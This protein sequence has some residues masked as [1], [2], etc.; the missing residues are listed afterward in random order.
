MLDKLKRILLGGGIHDK[1]NDELLDN[2]TKEQLIELVNKQREDAKKQAEELRKYKIELLKRRDKREQ[3]KQSIDKYTEHNIS[4]WI[5]IFKAEDEK[6]LNPEIIAYDEDVSTFDLIKENKNKYF[7]FRP[8]QQRFIEDWSISTNELVILYYG[9]GSGKTLIAINCGEQF[10][11]LNPNSYVYFLLPASLV[12]NTIMKM[13]EVG[14]DPRRKNLDGEYVYKF[15]SYQQMMLSK[16]DIKPNSLLIIDEAHNLR[17]FKAKTISK[18]ISARKWEKTGDYSLVGN[19]VAKLLLENKNTFLRTIMMTGTLFCNSQDDIEA[20][21]A[22]GYKRAPLVDVRKSELLKIRNDDKQFERYYGGLISFFRLKEDDPDFPRKKYHFI[23]IEAEMSFGNTQEDPYYQIGRNSGMVEKC[24]WILEFL[25]SRPKEKTLLYAEF[26]ENAILILMKK[27][28]DSGFNVVEITGSESITEKQAGIKLYNTGKIKILVFSKAIKEGISFKE[29][30]NF[31][32]IQ[33]YWNYA[34]SE[35]IIARSVRLDSHIRKQ[36]ALVNIYCLIGVNSYDFKTL[37]G[38]GKDLGTLEASN[39]IKIINCPDH[40]ISKQYEYL[41]IYKK[42]L[43]DE[44]KKQKEDT[45]AKTIKKWISEANNIMNNNIKTLKYERVKR[46]ILVSNKDES[47]RKINTQYFDIQEIIKFRDSSFSRDTYIWDMMFNK[48]ENINMFEEKLLQPYL[49]FEKYLTNENNEFLQEYNLALEKLKSDGN[50]LSRKKEIELKRLMYKEIYDKR[51]QETNKT[52]IRFNNDSHFKINRNPDLQQLA[53]NQ[54]DEHTVIQKMKTLFNS[55]ASLSDILKSFNIDKQ[56][57]TNFQANFTTNENIDKIIEMSGIKDDNRTRLFVLEPTSGVG[58]V[59]SRLLSKCPNKSNFMIDSNEYHNVFYNF[60][61]I[62]FN[63]LDN[64]FI[65]NTDFM[66]FQ[67]KYPYHYI[68]GNPPFNLRMQQKKIKPQKLKK[69]LDEDKNVISKELIA[70]T[71]TYID[72]TLFDVD[73][74]AHA[75]NILKNPSERGAKDGG[76]LCMI[77][78]D[79]FM[80]DDR[81]MSFVKFKNFINNAKKTD[82]TCVNY[83]QTTDFDYQTEKTEGTTEMTT[84][85]PMICIYLRKLY[86]VIM[87]LSKKSKSDDSESLE[88]IEDKPEDTPEDEAE[89]E[90]ELRLENLILPESRERNYEVIKYNLD[91]KLMEEYNK[92][93]KR[94]P[95]I[96][97]KRGRPKKVVEPTIKKKRGRPKKVSE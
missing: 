65:Y 37:K 35:Q 97:K 51:I 59:I 73:F 85:Y 49:S 10:I 54:Y 58:G 48:Q 18:K 87:N 67:S 78:S 8:Y 42:Q 31:I 83:F 57:I 56:Q 82:N 1:E 84:K 50:T 75:Y 11:N 43:E 26:M 96:K 13:Y 23:P 68:L 12:I 5:D 71:I 93:M 7:K 29:T 32:F 86:N 55:N 3:N 38:G 62:L 39:K 9:V 61:K 64:V 53:Q 76:V 20:L 66:T 79:R 44:K 90:L 74:V 34:I 80:R 92:L 16:V 95:T 94:E 69:E 36:K 21:I 45:P 88:E 27:L 40:L 91:D 52:I 81:Y 28:S 63:G 33:P 89:K 24:K 4:K 19:K 6:H 25:K 41:Q 47:T 30:N 70:E 14:L 72:K 2:M 77:I 60:Q 46:I 15:V 17:N 22:I